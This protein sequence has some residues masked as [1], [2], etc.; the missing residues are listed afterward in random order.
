M[1]DHFAALGLAPSP[2]IDEE[3]LQTAFETRSRKLHPDV[4][5]GD[6]HAFRELNAARQ[7]LRDPAR[8][9]RHLLELRAPELLERKQAPEPWLTE[10]FMRAGAAVQKLDAFRTRE[11]SAGSPLA[12]AL[13]APEK[14]EL[15]EE[16]QAITVE[17][18]HKQEEAHQ[19]M[20]ALTPAWE[21]PEN[22]Q[23][24]AFLQQR[25]LY[26]GKW[27]ETLRAK[28]FDLEF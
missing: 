2:S 20:T 4:A 17:L 1:T 18:N 22:L 26:L 23:Q 15:V 7:T 19:S 16:L 27:S 12:K 28:M 25:L 8:R 14:M 5:G 3:T 11:Q 10:L 21:T 9:L 6:E 13:L 24:L